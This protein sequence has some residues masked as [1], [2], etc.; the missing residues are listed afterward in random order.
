MTLQ[1]FGF[2]EHPHDIGI[3]KIDVAPS[4]CAFFLDFS[5]PLSKLRQFGILN[6]WIGTTVG[7]VVP[8]VHKGEQ[9]AGYVIGVHRSNPYF[10]DIQKL[11]KEH[12]G[13]VREQMAS[14]ADGSAIVADFGKHF[15]EDSQC[16]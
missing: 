5:R 13:A 9:S 3:T 4:D 10:G 8:V 11:W 12:F 6:K 2:Q 14:P 1:L 15:P 7:L 16:L